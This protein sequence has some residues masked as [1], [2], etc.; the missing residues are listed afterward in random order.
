MNKMEFEDEFLENGFVVLRNHI[1]PNTIKEGK[2]IL[3]EVIAR[4]LGA[5]GDFRKGFLDLSQAED[6]HIL[7]LRLFNE[8]DFRGFVL[9]L[10]QSAKLL[11]K[12]TCLLGPDLSY[13]S[14]QLTVNV[15]EEKRDFFVKKWHQ[16]FWSGSGI[17]KI[18]I[19]SPMAIEKGMGGVEFVKGSH[20]WGHIPHKNR[21][22]IELPDDMQV[23]NP[24]VEEGD[25]VIFHS[26]AL[27]RTVPNEKPLPRFALPLFIR[28][29]YYPDS[30]ISEFTKW[31]PFNLSPLAKV[32]KKLGNPAFSPFRTLGSERRDSGVT[33]VTALRT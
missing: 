3:S 2:E 13:E 25:S 14:S 10:L 17:H 24:V 4:D 30:G 11:E 19:W 29:F 6:Q 32:H 31:T 8:L 5:T 33:P 22:P 26:L 27:H 12:L 18:G 20:L 9:K 1:E 28:N 7:Q 23:V 15:K 16:E 21:E